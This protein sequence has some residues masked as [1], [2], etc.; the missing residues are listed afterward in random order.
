MAEGP[1]REL[2]AASGGRFY[3]EEG[4][5]TLGE[6]VAWKSAAFSQRREVLFWNP[7]ALV[8]FVGLVTAEWVVLKFANLS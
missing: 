4:L 5:H 2:A 8:V 7:L 1:V 6:S 3:R